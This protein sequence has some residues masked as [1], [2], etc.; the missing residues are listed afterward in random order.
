MSY[1]LHYFIEAGK[2]QKFT[3]AAKK[4]FGNREKIEEWLDY[5]IHEGARGKEALLS[6]KFALYVYVK[7][8]YKFYLDEVIKNDSLSE[9]LLNIEK[10]IGASGVKESRIMN[11]HPWEIIYKYLAMIA[12]AR[13]EDYKANTYMEKASRILDEDG[14]SPEGLLQA[15]ICFGKYEY[16]NT[17]LRKNHENIR[18]LQ[19]Q[20]WNEILSFSSAA[21]R[22]YK[23]PDKQTSE[24][25]EKLMTYMYH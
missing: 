19:K 7:G 9:K 25:L 15:I 8:I 12:R 11:G 1:M 21:S 22:R 6:L 2:K 17:A 10:T 5:L 18:L 20:C 14:N 24:N 4:Y 3:E 16:A 23:N 13:K